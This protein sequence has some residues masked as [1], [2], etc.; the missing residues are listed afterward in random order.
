MVILKAVGCK[1]VVESLFWNFMIKRQ[2]AAKYLPTL[3]RS[4]FVVKHYQKFFY[5]NFFFRFMNNVFFR[6]GK[7]VRYKFSKRL[8]T[9]NRYM[10]SPKIANPPVFCS[11]FNFGKKNIETYIFLYFLLFYYFTDNNVLYKYTSRFGP[12]YAKT[13]L[14]DFSSFSVLPFHDFIQDA[15]WSFKA[16]ARL[17]IFPFSITNKKP[18]KNRKMKY[19]FFSL[20]KITHIKY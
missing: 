3:S 2:T 20:L 14:Y 7:I 11:V 6:N 16:F 8:I 12:N 19:Q 15:D 17:Y 13:D 18:Y 4:T 9:I 10:P 5:A 1:K